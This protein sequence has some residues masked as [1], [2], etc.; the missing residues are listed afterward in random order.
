[1]KWVSGIIL[2]IIVFLSIPLLLFFD[3][4]FLG[5]ET[6]ERV[7]IQIEEGDRA[8][9]IALVLEEIGVINSASSYLLYGRIDPSV[10]RLKAGAYHIHKGK[11]YRGLARLLS[12]GPD[13]SEVSIRVTEGWSLDDIV[14][15]L[16]E[17]HGVSEDLTVELIGRSV[18]KASFHRSLRDDYPFL[19]V[20]PPD[21]SLEG[22][23]FPDTYLVW[24]DQLPEGLVYKQL[25][26][27]NRQFGQI[28]IS[29]QIAPLESLDDVITLAS[30]VEREVHDDEDRRIVA[31]IFL[32]RLRQGMRLQSDATV[33][34]LTGSS[35][36][37]STDEDLA[38]ESP[39][40][41]Y[42]V[43]GLPPSPVGNPGA[44]AIKAVLNPAETDYLFFLTTEEGDVLYAKNI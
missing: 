18:N 3:D 26:E 11:S 12:V 42:R 10:N 44:S 7:T 40:N 31:G 38:I 2:L 22:Y 4:A 16:K 24:E 8:A 13:R 33:S 32:N 9:D 37:R 41:S 6:D 19:A 21:R 34:Y 35:R 29:S 27:F 23:L 39:Y 30:I 25:N 1:M 28:E 36:A 17:K 14:D 20:L 43:G 5:D 15:L